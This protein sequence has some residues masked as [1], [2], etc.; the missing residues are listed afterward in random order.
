[1]PSDRAVKWFGDIVAAA[2][3]VG[4]WSAEAGGPDAATA[5]ALVRS[6]IERQLLIISEAAKRLD[7]LD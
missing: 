3:L 2:G 7:H 1:M 6:A 5:D 4:R